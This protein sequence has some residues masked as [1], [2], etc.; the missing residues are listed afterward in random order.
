MKVRFV[1]PDLNSLPKLLNLG[2]SIGTEFHLRTDSLYFV[3]GIS[4]WKSVLHYLVVPEDISLPFWYPVDIF[5]VEDSK[6]PSELYFCNFEDGDPTERKFL[7]GYKEMV[8]EKSHYTSLIER[9][10]EAIQIFLERKK[11]IESA[12]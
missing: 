3:Y 11:E 4:M 6:L 7:L 8:Q 5:E 10:T 9:E 12:L 1:S 2:Y